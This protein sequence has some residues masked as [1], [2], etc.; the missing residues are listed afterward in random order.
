MVGKVENNDACDDSDNCSND[1]V[2]TE[3]ELIYKIQYY[4]N[5]A[6]NQDDTDSNRHV[7]DEIFKAKVLHKYI[8][9]VFIW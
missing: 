5:T 2:S 8:I 9:T 7:F 3:E 1:V 6:P 4:P